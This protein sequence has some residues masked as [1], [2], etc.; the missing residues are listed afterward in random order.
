M[1]TSEHILV[2]FHCCI[3]DFTLNVDLNLPGSGLT[4][5]FGHSGCGKTTL[6]RCIAGLQPA[7]GELMV[8]GD[9]WHSAHENRPVHQRPLAYVFQET[10]LFPHLSVERNLN[11]GYRRVPV[12]QRRI[13]FDQAVE[14]L[15][16]AH[17]LKRMPQKLSGGERQRVAIAR[18]LLTSP[19]LLLLDEPVSALDEPGKRDVL[20]YLERLRAHLDIPMVYVSHSVSEVARLADHLVIMREGKVAAEG[21]LQ[22]VLSRPDQPLAL[23]D[24]ASVIVPATIVKQDTQWHLCL[25]EFNGG[26]FWLRDDRQLKPGTPVRLQVMARDVSIALSAR[27]DQSIQNVVAATVTDIAPEQ[28]PGVTTLRLMAGNTPFLARLTSRSVQHLELQEGASVW[29]Q[30]KSVAIIE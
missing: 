3:G 19:R 1:S 16:L 13:Q 30:V 22:T 6:L 18:A 23:E 27:H 4:A 21:D 20:G 24:D 28:T 7:S 2:R 5:L 9:T 26:Q 8:N 29:L 10:S 12:S 25:A 17:L 14:W 11:Y 15:G